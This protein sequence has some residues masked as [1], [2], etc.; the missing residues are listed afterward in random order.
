[1]KTS[2]DL[3]AI[4]DIFAKCRGKSGAIVKQLNRAGISHLSYSKISTYEYCPQ[5]YYLAYVRKAR[6]EP[7]PT[8]FIKGRIFHE[9]AQRFYSRTGPRAPEVKV[10]QRSLRRMESE[11][12]KTHLHNAVAMLNEN[13]WG[14]EWEVVG[15]EVPFAMQISAHLPPLVGVIDLVLRNGSQFA[16]VDHKTGTKFNELDSMQLAF[17]REH[18]RVGMGARRVDCFYDQ[19]RWVKDRSRLRKPGFLRT[20]LPITSRDFVKATARANKA[21]EGMREI[22]SPE[23]R[24]F[25]QKCF[26]CQFKDLCRD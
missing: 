20:R 17:Y 1:M 18:V 12:D 23:A 15:T 9:A 25:T 19:Y 10:D 3:Q 4:Q 14:Q 13:S 5:K 26:A 11:E 8:Y 22:S 2:E 24:P 6:I 21:F 7:E 16:I